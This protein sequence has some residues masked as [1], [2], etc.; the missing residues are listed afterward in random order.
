MRAEPAA[1]Y[2]QGLQDARSCS[3]RVA[4][5]QPLMHARHSMCLSQLRRDTPNACSTCSCCRLYKTLMFQHPSL[6]TSSSEAASSS[7]PDF[8]VGVLQSSRCSSLRSLI[9][10]HRG[11]LTAEFYLSWGSNTLV[12]ELQYVLWIINLRCIKAATPC[13]RSSTDIGAA[14]RG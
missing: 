7:V 2:L 5:R 10:N 3:W 6:L 4:F 11:V 9:R 8:M 14:N 12:C 1:R 13:L